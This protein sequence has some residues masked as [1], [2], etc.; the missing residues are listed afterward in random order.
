MTTQIRNGDIKYLSRS[1]IVHMMEGV[2]FDKGMQYTPIAIA[3]A[4]QLSSVP[5]YETPQVIDGIVLYPEPEVYEIVIVEISAIVV[6]ED[7]DGTFYYYE[8][9]R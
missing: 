4:D 7:D 5:S 8:I 1:T 6:I 2:F 9:Q 3:V